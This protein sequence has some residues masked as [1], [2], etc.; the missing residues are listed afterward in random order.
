[1]NGA[2][3]CGG[4]ARDSSGRW[5]QGFCK[6]LGTSNPLFA[7]LWA[8]RTAVEMLGALKQPRVVIE[9]DSA[10]ALAAVN[11]TSTGTLINPYRELVQAI[12]N[13]VP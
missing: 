12:H 5:I 8:I 2:S 1:M 6:Q 9:C 7:E 4:V 3:A 11:S 13:A 10:E